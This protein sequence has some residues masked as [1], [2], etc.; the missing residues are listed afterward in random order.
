MKRGDRIYYTGDMANCSSEGTIT[1][2]VP[3]TKY[4]A[5][6]V[7]IEFDDIR[8]EGDTKKKSNVYIQCFEPGPGRRFWMMDEWETDRQV[9]IKAMQERMLK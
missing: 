3:A 6:S 8:F 1:E 4:G 7:W 2:V 9:R 5:E